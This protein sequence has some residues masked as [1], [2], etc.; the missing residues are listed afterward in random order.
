ME[1][2]T[3]DDIWRSAF[4]TALFDI[5]L[6]AALLW[7]LKSTRLR[8]L[9]RPIAIAA[10]LFWGVFAT[11]LLFMFWDDYYRF[12]FPVW[13][14]WVAPL[15]SLFYAAVGVLLWWLACKLPG[16][17]VLNFLLLGA[18][19]SIPEHLY[20][21]YGLHILDVPM[22]R[23]VTPLP[24]FVYALFE[25]IVYWGAVLVLAALIQWG[26]ERRK[27]I[28]H[29]EF[30]QRSKTMLRVS[31]ASNGGDGHA[32][33]KIRDLPVNDSG[34][35]SIIPWAAGVPADRSSDSQSRRSGA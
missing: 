22:F 10:G 5:V 16:N 30:W 11:W 19:E 3:I 35:L 26:W 25:Y 9:G 15:D 4:F 34:G 33:T 17:P 31:S 23:G 32:P 1:P 2:V 12:F 28:S 7:R 20:G 8:A 13:A 18:L 29:L 27:V 21:I 6:I 24:V 14:P